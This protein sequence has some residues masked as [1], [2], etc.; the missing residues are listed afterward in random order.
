MAKER[1]TAGPAFAAPTPV[2]VRMPVPTIAPTPSAIRC[3]QERLRESRCCGARSSWARIFF[4]VFHRAILAL[5]LILL[6]HLGPPRRPG[7]AWRFGNFRQ[8]AL[9]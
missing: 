7:Q 1:I 6:G 5:P 3:G 9:A 2:R 4:F 8:G